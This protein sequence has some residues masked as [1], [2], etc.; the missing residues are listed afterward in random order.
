MNTL[1]QQGLEFHKQGNLIKAKQLYEQALEND[2][3]DIYALCLLGIIEYK[4]KNYESSINFLKK[5][6][7]INPDYFDANYNLACVLK[8]I[9]KLSESVVFSS[10]AVKSKINSPEANH[11]HADTLLELDKFDEAI[12]YYENVLKIRPNSSSAY[13]GKGVIFKEK[14][15]YKT[16][17][18][19]YKKSIELNPNLVAAYDNLGNIY[20]ILQMYDES[21]KNYNKAIEIKSNFAKAY[22]NRGALFQEMKRYDDSIADYYM[23]INLE[24][25]NFLVHLNLGV[26]FFE[27]NNNSRAL[28]F[29][30]K[31][32]EINPKKAKAYQ[33][34]AYILQELKQNEEALFNYEKAIS[35]DKNLNLLFSDYL[36]CK[37]KLC[38]WDNI[39]E[40]IKFFKKSLIN[41]NFTSIP[42]SLL[43]LIDDPKTHLINA[44]EYSK[45]YNSEFLNIHINKRTNKK[46]K[47]RIGYYSSDF[48]THAMGFLTENLIYAHNLNNF[49]IFAFSFFPYPGFDKDDLT[50]RISKSFTNFYDV[51]TLDDIKIV[52]LSKD[53]DI[54]IAVD[55]NGYTKYH[56]ANIFANRCAPIQINYLGYPGTSGANYIDYIIADKI[57]IPENEKIHFSEKVAYMPHCYQP[58]SLTN[59]IISQKQFFKK[60]FNLPD[61]CFIFCSFNS[62]HKIHPDTFDSWMS[63]LKSVK[64]SVLWLY[65]NHLDAKK[66]LCN[67]AKKRNVDPNRI[68]FATSLSNEEHLARL[69]LANLMLDTWPYNAHTSGSDA[70]SVGVPVITFCGNSFASRVGASLLTAAEIPELITYSQKDYENLAIELGN[71][72]NKF[73][74]L[75]EK[76]KNRIRSS[77]LFNNKNF[78][79]NIES[80]YSKMYDKHAQ[81]LVPDHI[82][83][84]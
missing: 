27:L 1:I 83:I 25:D 36:N 57:I 15:D 81:G 65:V 26:V 4:N 54:D 59:K 32:I 19:N 23:A 82:E 30:N 35:L 61:N 69:K 13:F 21:L 52:K 39:N 44:N 22:I 33:Y 74:L 28:D 42:I 49:D 71:N 34:K 62:N 8:E 72:K 80:L 20:K 46:N 68:I 56:R 16:A 67:E 38:N 66:N 75:Q 73:N 76:L 53:L 50:N 78:A 31:S 84:N 55:L 7:K 77:P 41:K 29:F 60:D 6:I 18:A 24:P 43:S 2:S 3:R 70:L 51:T 45:N 10:K 58:N 64:E 9:K 47:L 63:I 11:L 12:I 79:K 37:M 5:S 17:I 14:K 48:R 40:N